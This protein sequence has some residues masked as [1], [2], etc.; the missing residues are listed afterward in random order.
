ML[1]LVKVWSLRRA[2][3]ND[4]GNHIE[5]HAIDTEKE[6]ITAAVK[7]LPQALPSPAESDAAQED[8]GFITVVNQTHV[9]DTE[10]ARPIS[11][12]TKKNPIQTAKQHTRQII[13]RLRMVGKHHSWRS[14]DYNHPGGIECLSITLVSILVL[15]YF[16]S[17]LTLG[18]VGLGVWSHVFRPDI[19]HAD[20][21]SA[22]W[23]GA[24]LGTS[25]L[26]N[27]GMSLITTNMGPFQRE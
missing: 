27:N 10:G 3:S 13:T 9:G 4:L 24:F 20:G 7:E 15:I 22:F 5:C 17:F 11:I 19:A 16:V 18:I 6:K 2:L 1:S 12:A 26:C 21:V 23:G 14:I 8:Y 25:A